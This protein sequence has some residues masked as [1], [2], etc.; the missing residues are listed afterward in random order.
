MPKS[1]TQV[2]RWMAVLM[3]AMSL[4]GMSA[5]AQ[6]TTDGAIGGTVTDP[7]GAVVPNATVKVTN[8]GTNAVST[9]TSDGTGRYRVI[10][11]KPGDYKVEITSGSFAPFR[12]EYVT[13]EVGRITTIEA[14][15]SVGTTAETVDVTGE[16]P[17]VNTQAQDFSTNINQTSI[18]ELPINGRRWSQ[19]ASASAVSRVC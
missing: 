14:R 13:V 18:N 2:V 11:L 6:S 5:F 9:A 10:Q 1:T 3:L 12:A 16:A 15:L 7:S 17:Q 4:L 19:Y 8:M